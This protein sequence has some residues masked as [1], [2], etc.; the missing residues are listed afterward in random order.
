MTLMAFLVR[1]AVEPQTLSE[2][3]SDPEAAATKAGLSDE[4]RMILFSGDQNRIYA[5]LTQRQQV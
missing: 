4:D 5:A 1:L 2:F 3:V